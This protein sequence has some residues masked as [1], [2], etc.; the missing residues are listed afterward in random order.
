[1]AKIILLGALNF[2]TAKSNLNVQQTHLRGQFV[3]HLRQQ[4]KVIG[5]IVVIQVQLTFDLVVQQTG[6]GLLG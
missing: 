3:E 1:M 2:A 4:T 6:L 5:I